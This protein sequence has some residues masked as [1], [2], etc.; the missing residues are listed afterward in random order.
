MQYAG[1]SAL[2]DAK[3]WRAQNGGW[4][5]IADTGETVWFSLAF[6]PTPIMRHAAVRGLSGVLI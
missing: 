2:A 4:I 1:F 3:A 5:F 6:T